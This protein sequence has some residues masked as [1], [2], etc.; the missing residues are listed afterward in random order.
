MP[1][2]NFHPKPANAAGAC[3]DHLVQ[4]A[5]GDVEDEAPDRVFVR[6]ERAGLDAGDRLSHVLIQVGERLGG[7][8]RL[9]A[10]LVLD[11]A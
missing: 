4:L 9:D 2:T 3:L 10:G 5:C 6:D 7:P 8:F 1:D 11:G